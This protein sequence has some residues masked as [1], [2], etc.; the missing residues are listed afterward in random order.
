MSHQ[1]QSEPNA[2]ESQGDLHL[3]CRDCGAMF[4]FTV[5]ERRFFEERG[6]TPPRRCQPCRDA[7]KAE[8]QHAE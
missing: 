1:L 4:T 7:R 2:H 3:E 5:G 8:R 6:F